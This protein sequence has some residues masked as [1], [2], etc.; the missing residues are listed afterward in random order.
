MEELAVALDEWSAGVNR[1]LVRRCLPQKSLVV[2][3]GPVRSV[4]PARV[5]R[6]LL[7]RRQI[8][9]GRVVL[10]GAELTA[11][12]VRALGLRGAEAG[13]LMR[14]ADRVDRLRGRLGEYPGWRRRAGEQL[15]GGGTG[16]LARGGGARDRRGHRDGRDPRRPRRS[17]PDARGRPWWERPEG[18]TAVLGGAFA[19]VAAVT[20]AVS[21][22]PN[23]SYPQGNRVP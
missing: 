17:D 6:W 15:T 7:G 13:R 22:R 8:W 9:Q 1:A 10:P 11:D 4:D 19:V 14:E 5:S 21:T 3:L 16:S 18:V 20:V 23:G 12:I 2:R